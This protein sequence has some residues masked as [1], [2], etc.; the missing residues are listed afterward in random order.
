MTVLELIIADAISR[1]KRRVPPK[2]LLRLERQRA[3]VREALTHIGWEPALAQRDA[4]AFGGGDWEQY[5]RSFAPEWERG[6]GPPRGHILW[7]ANVYRLTDEQFM[8]LHGDEPG[9]S[10]RM[11]HLRVRMF[12]AIY[13]DESTNPALFW[14]SIVADP[15]PSTR[16]QPACSPSAVPN[17]GRRR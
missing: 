6:R 14:S 3:L 2:G 10:V 15:H 7:G 12:I 13:Q 9:L 17:R 11:T 1:A 5:V 8:L 4:E 16:R